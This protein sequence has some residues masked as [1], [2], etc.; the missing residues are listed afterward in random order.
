M[1]SKG[2]HLEKAIILRNRFTPTGLARFCEELVELDAGQHRTFS[3]EVR[4]AM[5]T[6]FERFPDQFTVDTIS[7][8][9]QSDSPDVVKDA[10]Y[11]IPS[12]FRAGAENIGWRFIDRLLESE[13]PDVAEHLTELIEMWLLGV[14]GFSFEQRL[15]L[16]SRLIAHRHTDPPPG[17]RGGESGDAG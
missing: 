4:S 7:A 15:Q 17:A 11:A 12:L 9:L 14:E 2:E 8:M 3:E 10:I 5:D 13:Y 6:L 16:A 1:A